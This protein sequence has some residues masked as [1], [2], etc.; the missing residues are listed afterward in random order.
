ME[1]EII[2]I[3]ENRLD[4]SGAHGRHQ[5]SALEQPLPQYRVAEIRLRLIEAGNGVAPRHRTAPQPCQLRKDE[6]HPMCLL[7]AEAQFGQNLLKNLTLRINEPRKIV[8]RAAAHVGWGSAPCCA[9]L[10]RRL[11]ANRLKIA[12]NTAW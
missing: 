6:P 1:F 8:V 2:R 3:G 9:S 7:E 5:P 4:R 10:A 12:N 11:S